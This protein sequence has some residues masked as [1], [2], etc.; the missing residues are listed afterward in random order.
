[1]ALDDKQMERVRT[2]L[3]KEKEDGEAD[4]HD[5]IE[6]MGLAMQTTEEQLD[7]LYAYKDAIGL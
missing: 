7:E 4:P 5:C 3:D 2:L 1:V 6:V